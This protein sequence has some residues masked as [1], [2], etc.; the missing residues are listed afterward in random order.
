[1]TTLISTYSHFLCAR[2]CLYVLVAHNNDIMWANNELLLVQT[3]AG[4]NKKN[5]CGKKNNSE[6]SIY[7]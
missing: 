6:A 7:N 2:V 5:G 4:G 1:M 3:P